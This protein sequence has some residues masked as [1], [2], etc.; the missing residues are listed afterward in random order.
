MSRVTPGRQVIQSDVFARGFNP[1]REE[2]AEV[3]LF[4][5]TSLSGRVWMP[6]ERETQ[7]LSD[8]LNTLG[9]NFFVLISPSGHH[10]INASAVVSVEIAE[11]AGAPLTS[12]LAG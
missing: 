9:T 8:Y 3:T 6:L 2:R 1:W 4:D 12:E 7:R 10:L 11:S 5:G